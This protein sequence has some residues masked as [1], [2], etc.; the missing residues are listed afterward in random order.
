MSRSNAYDEDLPPWRRDWTD[1]F[2]DMDGAD[3]A[4][5]IDSAAANPEYSPES[6]FPNLAPAIDGTSQG[7]RESATEDAAETKRLEEIVRW[8]ATSPLFAKRSMSDGFEIEDHRFGVL[9]NGSRVNL[10]EWLVSE[11]VGTKDGR[12]ILG[13]QVLN[14]AEALRFRYVGMPSGD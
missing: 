3:W 12:I 6:P 2:D 13:Y 11:G 8:L 7:H 4:E 1:S 10:K 9:R 14:E 5:Y